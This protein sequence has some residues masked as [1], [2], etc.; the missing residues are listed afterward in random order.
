MAKRIK[1]Q[2]EKGIIDIIVA[3]KREFIA[4]LDQFI[5]CNLCNAEESPFTD[6]YYIPTIDVIY[7]ERCFDLWKQSARWYKIDKKI[8]EERL[9]KLEQK[10]KDMGCWE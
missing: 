9:K 1:V 2:I 10:F 3:T 5:P 4:A 7:C 8:C 6:M